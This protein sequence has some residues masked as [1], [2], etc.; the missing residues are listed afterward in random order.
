[1]RDLNVIG[2]TD[3][4]SDLLAVRVRVRIMETVKGGGIP[5]LLMAFMAVTSAVSSETVATTVLL[6]YDLY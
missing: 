6:P 5:I 4:M 1:M 3:M 2:S